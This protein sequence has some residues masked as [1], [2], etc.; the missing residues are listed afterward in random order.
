M[1]DPHRPVKR[2]EVHYE[3]KSYGEA[4]I[5]DTYA[6]TKVKRNVT[7][8]GS[9]GTHDEPEDPTAGAPVEPEDPRRGPKSPVQSAFAASRIDVS[10]DQGAQE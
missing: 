5:V 6:N 9:L 8:T 3:G 2:L 4:K 7:S 10:S 1:F